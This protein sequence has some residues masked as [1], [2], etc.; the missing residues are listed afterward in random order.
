M[1]DIIVVGSRCAGAPTAMLFAGA[2]YRVL[3]LDRAKFPRDTLSTLYIHQP[4]I[5]LLHRWGLLDALV[6]SGCPPITSALHQVSDVR[7]QGCSQP[8]NGIRAAYAPRR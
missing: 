1:Y 3:M 7:L 6:A 4:G 2:G 5:A 8:V